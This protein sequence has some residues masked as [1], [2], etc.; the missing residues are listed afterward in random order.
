MKAVCS[1]RGIGAEHGKYIDA[2]D[3]LA[4][5]MLRCGITWA[6][7]GDFIPDCQHE[8]EDALVDWFYSSNWEPVRMEDMP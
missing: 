1:Y 6:P 7:S 8:F 3:A 5:A 2:C 4:Y